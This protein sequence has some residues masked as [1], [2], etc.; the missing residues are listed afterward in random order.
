MAC[1]DNGKHKMDGE[2][3]SSITRKRLQLSDDHGSDDSSHSPEEETEEE[4]VSSEE[5]LME[6][7][8][9]KEFATTATPPC[10]RRSQA[11]LNVIGAPTR[12]A[13]TT[14]MT[15]ITMMTSGCR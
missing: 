13:A 1:N 10:R 11:P 4:G 5:S 14:M 9:S 15:T 3:K 8:T 7:N 2:V 12:T 6:L